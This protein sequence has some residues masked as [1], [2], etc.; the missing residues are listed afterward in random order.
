MQAVMEATI[1]GLGLLGG[2]QLSGSNVEC[3]LQTGRACCQLAPCSSVDSVG[4]FSL[5]HKAAAIRRR[6]EAKDRGRVTTVLAQ[7]GGSSSMLSLGVASVRSRA[8]VVEPPKGTLAESSIPQKQ[9][10]LTVGDFMTQASDLFVANIDTTVDEALEILV[11]KRITGMPVVDEN[12]TLVGVVSDYDLLALDS[13]SGKRSPESSL[14]P[15]PGRT[16]RPFKEIQ[17]LLNKTHGKTV[18]EVMT[19]SPLVVQETTNLEDAAKLLLDSKF[20]RLPVVD[21][22]GRL[23]GLLTRGNVVRAA[24]EMKRAAMKADG[25]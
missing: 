11:D 7:G 1:G 10:H 16:W 21:E 6:Q 15:E 18:G 4:L 17:K 3:Q 23:I 8:G 25:N 2:V 5:S 12:W 14:F 9:G 20:R 19:P 22:K 24:L 13:I